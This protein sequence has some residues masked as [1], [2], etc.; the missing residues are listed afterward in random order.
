MSIMGE[1]TS[2]AK[3]E[4]RR[5][6][7][8]CKFPVP[9]AMRATDASLISGIRGAGSPFA[10]AVF[11]QGMQD[12]IDTANRNTFIAVQIESVEGLANCEEIAKVDGIGE[13][14]D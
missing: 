2:S 13:S 6:V 5:F 9:T 12:Y 1:L 7:S 3:A 8:F 11:K 14:S 10:P 4:A